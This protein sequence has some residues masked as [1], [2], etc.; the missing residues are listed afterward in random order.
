M[1]CLVYRSTHIRGVTLM[2]GVLRRWVAGPGGLAVVVALGVSVAGAIAVPHD[3]ALDTPGQGA[4]HGKPPEGHGSMPM[5]A[6]P[7]AA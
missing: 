4:H 5:L 3:A 1:Q 6:V 7:A 2:W